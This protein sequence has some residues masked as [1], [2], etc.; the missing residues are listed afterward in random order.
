[1]DRK[2]VS[3]FDETYHLHSNFKQNTEPA[4]PLKATPRSPIT[5]LYTRGD[6]STRAFADGGRQLLSS[7]KDRQLFV[8]CI[9]L[10]LIMNYPTNAEICAHGADQMNN[11]EIRIYVVL[12]I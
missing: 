12:L 5:R 8:V 3:Q 11:S 2:H 6:R 1:M 9:F 4:G 10:I 7:G